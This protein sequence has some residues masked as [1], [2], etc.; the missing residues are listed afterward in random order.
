MEENNTAYRSLCLAT[1]H[2]VS[3]NI[4]NRNFNNFYLSNSGLIQN[5]CTV[6]IQHNQANVLYLGTQTG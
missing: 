2:N 5:K 1:M 3:W 6:Y 4:L